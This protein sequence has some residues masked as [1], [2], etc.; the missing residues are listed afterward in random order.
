MKAPQLLSLFAQF[1]EGTGPTRFEFSI[2]MT[3]GRIAKTGRFCCWLKHS[4]HIAQAMAGLLR[5]LNAPAEVTA[6]PL[7]VADSLMVCHGISVAPGSLRYYRHARQ[8]HGLDN[9]Y[10]AWRWQADQPEIETCRYRCSYPPETPD[11]LKPLDLVPAE[12]RADFQALMDEPRF[13][14]GSAFWLR[15]SMDQRIDQLDLAFPWMPQAGSLAGL[16]SLA[17]RMGISAKSGWRRLP[18]RHVA[19]ALD[20]PQ[21]E[22]TL[23]S[24]A[25]WQGAWPKTEAELQKGVIAQAKEIGSFAEDRLYRRLPPLPTLPP[26]GE[27]SP[28]GAFYDGDIT[29]WKRVLGADLHYHFGIFDDQAAH[30]DAAMMAAAQCRAVSELYPLLPAG[31]TIYDVGC[32]WGGPM[33]MWVRDLGCPSVGLTVS[34]DQYR[35]V[36][37]RGLPVRWGDAESTLP[38]GLFDCAVMLESLCHM[39]DKEHVLRILR[40]HCGRLVMRVH[41]Q[42]RAPAGT[43]F[44]GTMHMISSQDL[45]ALLEQTGWTIRHWQNRRF[46]T[47][48]NFRGWNAAL[49]GIPP[50]GHDHIEVLRSW[51]ARAEAILADWAANNPLIEVMAE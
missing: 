36:A 21:P 48:P 32:G 7:A 6:A 2:R 44:G 20:R 34:R 8:P 41:C 37:S 10:R 47:L 38:P 3:P 35:H 26:S 43:V 19:L 14:L 12:L 4:P 27:V 50:T 17:Q 46:Q 11:G 42:D 40:V 18:V 16:Q 25:P 30:P 23:Y 28:I 1:L 9:D 45:R 51:S 29:L 15:S 24:S 5:H 39:R 13:R 49:S 31:R 22:I 33:S